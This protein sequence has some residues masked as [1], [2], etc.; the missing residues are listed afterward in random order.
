L[1]IG[2]RFDTCVACHPTLSY[3]KYHDRSGELFVENGFTARRRLGAI[4]ASLLILGAAVLGACGA[5][6]SGSNTLEPDDNESPKTLLV[7]TAASLKAAFTE[8]GEAFDQAGGTETTFTFDASGTLQKQIEAGAPVDVFVS[9]SPI[10]VDNLLEKGLVDEASVTT[11]ASNEMVLAVPTDSKL[12]IT[13]F[14]DLAKDG[15]KRIA[16]ADPQ[17]A[18]QGKHALEVLT[19][20]GLLEAV[21]PKLIYSRSAPQTL[22]YVKQGE[23]DAGIMFSTDA[24]NGGNDVRIVET[25]DPT[26]HSEIAYVTAV[27]SASKAKTQGQAFIAFITGPEGRSV[28]EKHGFVVP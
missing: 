12:D 28:L 3:A 25:S 15:V 1:P 22:T 20:L 2:R 6:T 17:T 26:W 24:L 16:T 23:V 11:F 8:I 5:D 21:Q 7:A 4:L 19:S 13:S 27:V 9:A 10:Q 18:P 14:Q